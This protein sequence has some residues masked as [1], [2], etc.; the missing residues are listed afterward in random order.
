MDEAKKYSIATG[1]GAQVGRIGRGNSLDAPAGTAGFK[2]A[3]F[4]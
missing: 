2:P 3:R 4:V 1:F